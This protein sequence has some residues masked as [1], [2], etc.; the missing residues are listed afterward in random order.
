MNRQAFL[1]LLQRYL[2]NSCTPAEK[3]VMDRWYDLLDDEY[4]EKISPVSREELQKTLWAKIKDQISPAEIQLLSS[5]ERRWWWRWPLYRAAASVLLIF[6]VTYLI[7]LNNILPER[8]GGLEQA[9]ST[10][11]WHE[12]RNTGSASRWLVLED[13]TRISLEPGSRIRYATPMSPELRSVQLTGNAFF[14]VAKDADRPF[15]V[16]SGDILTK[17]VGTSFR[18]RSEGENFEVSVSTGRVVVEKSP[19]EGAG[20]PRSDADGVV[21]TPNQKVTYFTKDRHFV[22]GLVDNPLPVVLPPTLA[23]EEK[24]FRFEEVPLDQVLSR[25]EEVY[26]V[27]VILVNESLH[28]CP[29][30]ADL[31]Q[32]PLYT[33]L[34]ILG[35]A[36]QTTFEVKGTN[37]VLSGG[38]CE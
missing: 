30:T 37:I 2:D 34:E 15:V 5:Q 10:G 12:E 14:D 13:S 16:H 7:R 1:A 9:L 20:S 22:M 38:N 4:D 35:A 32:Q 3:Q 31:S 29:V 18:I 27:K 25:I 8:V 11:G 28:S 17:V 26:G 24:L 33:K 23:V 19:Q 21:L 36:L 6:G